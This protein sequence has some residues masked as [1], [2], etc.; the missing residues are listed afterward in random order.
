MK[1]RVS[2][3]PGQTSTTQCVPPRRAQ[4]SSSPSALGRGVRGVGFGEHRGPGVRPWHSAGRFWGINILTL[5]MFAAASVADGYNQAI[6]TLLPRVVKLYGVGVGEQA[7]YGSGILVSEDGL[8]LTV[9]SLLIDARSLRAVTADGTTYEAEVLHRDVDKQLALLRI[10]AS[11]SQSLNLPYFDIRCRPSDAESDLPDCAELTRPGDWIIA[12]GNSFK[13]A[14]GAEPVSLAHGVVST[15]ARLDA[16]RRIKDHPYRGDVLVIDAITSNPGAPGSAVV[17]LEGEFVGMIGRVVTSNLTHT[18]FNYAMPR[19]VL[20]TYVEEAKSAGA[21]GTPTLAR[22]D[23]ILE[24][25]SPGPK[26]EIGLRITRTGYNRLP[27]MV[28]RVQ[29]GSPAEKAGL[30]KDDVILSVDGRTVN[31]VAD[32]DERL[33]M[34][35]PGEPLTIVV[36]RG[37]RILSLQV[38]PAAPALTGNEQ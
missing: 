19:D 7:G 3:L 10:K 1:S 24:T 20:A 23:S 5:S 25:Q 35:L 18:N 29:W 16:R 36:R 12:A 27:P 26:V 22:L 38:T 2:P 17:N 37:E 14:D 6:D 13:V 8:I 15:R 11:E 9:F 32:Y 33:A 31:D 30:R 28:D 21:S 34:A 4:W